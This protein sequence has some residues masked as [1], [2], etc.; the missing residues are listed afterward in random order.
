MCMSCGC[1]EPNE[2]HGNPNN[3]TLDDLRKAA[4]AA[5]IETEK[6]ADNIHEL[7]SKLKKEGKIE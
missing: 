2:R 7:A 4:K 3:I 1:G 6:A 5:N